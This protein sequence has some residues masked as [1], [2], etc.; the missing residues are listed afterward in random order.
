M[1]NL[2]ETINLR[3]QLAGHNRLELLLFHL[4]GGQRYGINVFKVREVIQCPPLT[5]VP[6]AH[7]F[8]R[9]LAHL[10]GRTLPMLDL[11]LAISPGPC[12]DIGQAYALITEYNLTVQGFVVGGV[13]RIVNMKWEEILPPPK[14]LGRA[15][16]LTA[17]T[18][19][20]GE[21]VE[22]I[23]VEK[24]LAEV[25]GMKDEITP[26]LIPQRR[27]GAR[28]PHILVADDSSV[29]RNQ[30]RRVL[31]KLGAECTLVDNGRA[32]LE[33]LQRSAD[34]GTPLQGRL[35]MVISDIEMPEMDGYTLTSEIRRD[36]RLANLYVLLHTSLSGVFNQTMVTRVGADRFIAKFQPDGLATA[37][38]EVLQG[39]LTHAA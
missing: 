32:A 17:V 31:E 7:P 6:E 1:S 21:L 29:A 39:Q 15:S 37:V 36:P 9:G 16:Y 20:D 18:R 12:A 4:N 38:L 10:R 30:I 3:T 13:D 22:I 19:M 33:W 11:G 26:G 8:V 35:D 14:G 23:D 28:T 34:E 5:H 2:L 27:E 24:V 25:I